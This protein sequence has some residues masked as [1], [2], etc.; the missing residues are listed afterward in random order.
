MDTIRD[1]IERIIDA[2]ETRR[3]QAE[4]AGQMEAACAYQHAIDL[5]K[6]VVREQIKYLIDALETEAEKRME[7]YRQ[8]RDYYDWG[9]AEGLTYAIER[10][11]GLV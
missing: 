10:L 8:E 11:K 9:F 6:A 2:L 3:E 5:L 1:E 4:Q 7:R